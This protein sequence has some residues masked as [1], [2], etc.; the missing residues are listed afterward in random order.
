M[1]TTRK[2]AKVRARSKKD[3]TPY[4]ISD[5]VAQP[6]RTRPYSPPPGAPRTRPLRIFTLDPSASGREAEVAQLASLGTLLAALAQRVPPSQREPQRPE[7][8]SGGSGTA[9]VRL[10]GRRI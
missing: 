8:A 2:K 10:A 9:D 3:G 6:A 5:R 7:A 4:E 1:P